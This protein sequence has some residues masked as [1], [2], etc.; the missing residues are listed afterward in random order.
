MLRCAALRCMCDEYVRE[1]VTCECTNDE[2]PNAT[3]KLRTS[4]IMEQQVACAALWQYFIAR[5]L[6][7][8]RIKRKRSDGF[9]KV[10]FYAN[11]TLNAHIMALAY[12]SK[13]SPVDACTSSAARTRARKHR[14]R[15]SVIPDVPRTKYTSSK[16]IT[17]C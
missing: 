15:L 3:A 1:C 17:S 7:I 14:M 11:C 2:T 8:I 4:H 12:L 9:H 13:R 16:P 5:A 6:G 10:S